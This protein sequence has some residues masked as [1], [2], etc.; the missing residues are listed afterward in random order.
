MPATTR[1]MKINFGEMRAS[2]IRDLLIYLL[3]LQ[4]RPLHDSQRRSLA[5]RRQALGHRTAVPLQRLR[6]YRC[7]GRFR[8]RQDGHGLMRFTG[9]AD[10]LP[11]FGHL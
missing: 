11:S 2:G 6:E 10:L 9:L 5:G 7:P 8:A 4:V 1:P 3:R